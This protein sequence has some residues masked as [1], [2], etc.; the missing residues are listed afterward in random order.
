MR[1]SMQILADWLKKYNPRAV[2]TEDSRMIRNVRPL[3]DGHICTPNNIYVSRADDGVMCINRN[4]VLYLHTD[5]TDQVT[6]DIMDAFDFYNTWQDE[7]CLLLSELSLDMLLQRSRKVLPCFLAVADPSYFTLAA[8]GFPE[9]TREDSRRMSARTRMIDLPRILNLEQEPAI[10]QPRR[11]SYRLSSEIFPAET[12]VRNLFR[13]NQHVGWLIMAHS[14]LTPGM[15]DIQDEVGDLIESWLEL[16]TPMQE[17]LNRNS[18]LIELLRG[19]S[20]DPRRIATSLMLLGIRAEDAKMLYRIEYPDAPADSSVLQHMDAISPHCHNLFYEKGL[21]SIF[22]GP[23]AERPRFEAELRD[24]LRRSHGI[25]G[26]SGAFTDIL[27]LREQYES[28]SAALRFADT[29]EDIRRFSDAVLPYAL[30]RLREVSLPWLTHPAVSLLREYDAQNHTELE[31]TLRVYLESERNY[32]DT[33]RALHIHRNSLLYRV[34]RIR[35]LTGLRLEDPGVRL[36]LLL[37]F[38]VESGR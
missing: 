17:R 26:S 36:H 34:E 37:S 6:N 28:A 20:A 33:A 9:V 18:L 1:L 23:E 4:N 2:I 12:A 21:V 13:G 38:A 25:C 14:A 16:H 7:M 15:M 11:S 19:S 22:S 27:S 10:R 29:S 31:K 32:A 3:T 30:H 35:E 8:E 24:M 5:D